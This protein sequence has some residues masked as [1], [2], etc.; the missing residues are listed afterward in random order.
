MDWRLLVIDCRKC[1]A[2][3]DP[4]VGTGEPVV[5][6][7]TEAVATMVYRARMVVARN[8]VVVDSWLS[9]CNQVD[10]RWRNSRLLELN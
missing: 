9:I 1:L 3:W 7:S 2:E 8:T 4:M 10:M 5:A 6:W